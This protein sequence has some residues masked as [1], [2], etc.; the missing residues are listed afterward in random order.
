MKDLSIAYDAISAKKV[1]DSI[2]DGVIAYHR[3]LISKDKGKAEYIAV[4]KKTQVAG[5]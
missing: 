1:F 3:Y 2:G 5:T 4:S